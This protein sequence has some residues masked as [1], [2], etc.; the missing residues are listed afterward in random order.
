VSEAFTSAPQTA[1]E[2]ALT[3]TAVDQELTAVNW[4]VPDGWQQGRG[5]WGGLV[6]GAQ[7]FAVEKRQEVDRDSDRRVRTISSQIF[8]PVPVGPSTISVECLRR[9]S[10]MSTWQTMVRDAA[11]AALA[12]AVVITGT[13]RATDLAGAETHWG[14]APVPSLGSW[15]EVP[16]VSIDPPLGPV[17]SQH[18]EYRP[19]LGIPMSGGQAR[20][21]GWIGLVGL[22]A[23][24]AHLLLGIADAWWPAAYTALPSPRPMATVS[25]GAHLLLD[26]AEISPAEPLLHEALVTCAEDGYTSEIRRLWTP[27]GRLVVENHQ[28]IVVVA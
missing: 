12:Q 10:G 7:V 27:D 9:G 5:A 28:S 13:P 8:A 3:L 26:P 4:D 15:Q 6:I 22:S 23:W 21:E 17:F 20:A 18:L 2:G 1:L 24:S 14:L 16:V 11:G 19:R 25:F